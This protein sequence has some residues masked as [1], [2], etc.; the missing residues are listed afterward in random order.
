MLKAGLLIQD[1]DL[2]IDGSERGTP[3]SLAISTSGS[4]KAFFET[5]VSYRF[6]ERWKA[7]LGLT[8]FDSVGDDDETG[9]VEI[10]SAFVGVSYQF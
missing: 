5:G 8:F 3:F 6:N 9:E 4:P 1:V 7:T 2:R 10:R